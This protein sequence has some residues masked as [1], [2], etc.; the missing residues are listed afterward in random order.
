MAQ[1]PEARFVNEWLATFHPN[2]LQ[3]R[4]VRL[5]TVPLV[6]HARLYR[7]TLRF[8]D[9]IFLEDDVV[10]IVEAKL[11]KQAEAMGQ[12]EL[13]RELYRK[14]PEFSMFQDK[15]VKLILLTPRTDEDLN[16]LAAM[17]GIQV[18]VFTPEWLKGVNNNAKTR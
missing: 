4:R 9:A 17:K 6:E 15:Q 14:T 3:W 11:R 7:V 2:A 18:V 5:G 12:L 8:A 10:H 1:Q 16:N 13:Y